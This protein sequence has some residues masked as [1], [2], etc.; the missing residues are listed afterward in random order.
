MGLAAEVWV[1]G[2]KTGERA[3]R[4]FRFDITRQAKA[5]RNTLRVRVAN[6]NAGWLAQG[7]T[8]YQKGSWGLKYRT[9]RDRIP[10][11]R[12]NGL[13]GPVRVVAQPR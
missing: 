3:W 13:E 10:F 5:G 4:P 12:P 2:E 1:N 9:E 7:D 11:M 8:V 6:S